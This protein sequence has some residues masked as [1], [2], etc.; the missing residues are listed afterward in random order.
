MEF[1]KT[2]V[3]ITSLIFY[4]SPTN[5]IMY[6]SWWLL[7]LLV[8]TSGSARGTCTWYKRIEYKTMKLQHIELPIQIKNLTIIMLFIAICEGVKVIY[9]YII[10]YPSQPRMHHAMR[11]Q[12]GNTPHA[13]TR[14]FSPGF[15]RSRSTSGSFFLDSSFFLPVFW[16]PGPPP[17]PSFFHHVGLLQ[18]R[19]CR[20]RIHV[21]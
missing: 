13:P 11:S 16:V 3:K 10:P 6:C 2:N 20:W 9:I 15:P 17:V 5:S 1:H 21:C 12:Y 19:F 14:F 4:P 7:L 8:Q 18:I